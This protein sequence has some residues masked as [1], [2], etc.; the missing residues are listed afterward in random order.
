MIRL[1]KLNSGGGAVL[2]KLESMEPCNS[3]KDRIGKS[4]VE[5]AEKGLIS[6][7]KQ[8]W[9]SVTNTGTAW[10]WLLLPRVQADP[11][12]T[13]VHVLGRRAS[14]GS[15]CSVGVDTC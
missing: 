3:V 14:Q 2:L 6:L 7:R 15:G 5:E 12:H 4:M 11:D 1:N 13:C 10:P 8:L 9:L